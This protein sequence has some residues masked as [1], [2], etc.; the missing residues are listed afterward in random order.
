MRH[1]AQ[2][3]VLQVLGVALLPVSPE[4]SAAQIIERECPNV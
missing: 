2:Q 1:P 3:A 4:T